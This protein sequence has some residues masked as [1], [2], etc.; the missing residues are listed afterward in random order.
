MASLNEKQ[1]LMV[2]K[3]TRQGGVCMKDEV[4]PELDKV[5]QSFNCPS[6]G[7]CEPVE[8]DFAYSVTEDKHGNELER[9]T[10]KA[11]KTSCCGGRLEIWDERIEDAIPLNDVGV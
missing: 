4:L 6:C 8:F 11:Y 1:V 10:H 3:T 5:Y 7:E 2:T 9:K